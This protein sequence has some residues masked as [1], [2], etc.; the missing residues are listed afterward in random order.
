MTL[1]FQGYCR[2]FKDVLEAYTALTP[3]VS[4]SGPTSF[5]PLIYQAIEI[6]KQT[7]SVGCLHIVGERYSCLD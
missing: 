7:K 3:N 4:M 2:G 5:A 6:V 1:A